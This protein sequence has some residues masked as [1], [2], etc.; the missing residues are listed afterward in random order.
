MRPSQDYFGTSDTT[1]HWHL[2]WTEWTV[3]CSVGK[4]ARKVCPSQFYWCRKSAFYC[5]L[6]R[7]LP[8][9]IKGVRSFCKNHQVNIG[10]TK[11]TNSICSHY[12]K[13]KFLII[14]TVVATDNCCRTMKYFEFVHVAILSSIFAGANA[15]SCQCKDLFT[16]DVDTFVTGQCCRQVDGSLSDTET[17][18]AAVPNNLQTNFLGCCSSNSR[19]GVCSQV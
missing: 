9:H 4:S 10:S 12:S 5:Y 6:S 13:R 18:C 3:G 1:R 14:I 8:K 15:A 16:N 2:F 11:I 7:L 19:D 17:I